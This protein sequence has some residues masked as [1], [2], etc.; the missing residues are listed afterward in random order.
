MTRHTSQNIAKLLQDI[1]IEWGIAENSIICSVTDNVPNMRSVVNL[2]LG[3]GKHISCFAHT[4]NLCVQDAMREVEEFQNIV[5]GVKEIV[6]FFKRSNTA[7]QLLKEEQLKMNDQDPLKLKQSCETRWNSI[8]IMLERF[9]K[10]SHV[11][12]SITIQV[13]IPPNM[14]AF[15]EL[16]IIQDS[17]DVLKPFLEATE[18]ISAEKITT[19]SKV[20]PLCNVIESFEFTDASNDGKEKTSILCNQVFWVEIW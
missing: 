20:I 10:L 18:E 14:I 15:S 6:S 11:I 16:R 7:S 5:N 2:F 19:L 13:E 4:L 9:C 12:S 3:E 8:Y 1:V 17:L